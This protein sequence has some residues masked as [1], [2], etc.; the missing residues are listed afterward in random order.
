[1]NNFFSLICKLLLDF[2]LFHWEMREENMKL[3]RTHMASRKILLNCFIARNVKS[4]PEDTVQMKHMAAI[5][6]KTPNEFKNM[7]FM[8]AFS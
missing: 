5:K 8:G 1:M 3:Q 4:L 2:P 7:L 6:K